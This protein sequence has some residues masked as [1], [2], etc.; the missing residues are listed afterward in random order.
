MR[1]YHTSSVEE[2]PYISY[3]RSTRISPI[4]GEEEIHH[5]HET[6]QLHNKSFNQQE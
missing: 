4:F 5:A 2:S 1:I 3:I 6:E